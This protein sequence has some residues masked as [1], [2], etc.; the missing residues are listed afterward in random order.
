MR[1]SALLDRLL[2]VVMLTLPASLAAA[3][4][5]A[6]SRVPAAHDEARSPTEAQPTEA[7]ADA[8]QLGR[9]TYLGA[10]VDLPLG[11]AVALSP[12]LALLR[13]AP[14]TSDE[15]TILRS[16]FGI[17]TTL[18][19]DDSWSIQVSGLYGPLAFDIETIEGAIAVEHDI[20]SDWEHEVPPR[21]ELQLEIGVG[22]FR[23]ADGLGPAGENLVQVMFEV[24]ELWRVTHRFHL[25]P[26]GM[27]FV[28]DKSLDQAVGD[29]LGSAM[30]LARVGAFAP[31]LALGGA[32]AAYVVAPWITPYAEVD[33]ILYASR[34]GDAT[35]LLAGASF[36]LGAHVAFGLGGG[37]LLNRPHG[38]LVPDELANRSL[39][40]A[41]TELKLGF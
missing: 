24:K 30:A 36:H 28:Y 9:T 26:Q 23:W 27:F 11:S 7:S 34:S 40:L 33:E 31:P 10:R 21:A 41:T 4:G 32:R 18:R 39:P 2:V 20:G 17:G 3:G 38:P 25:T 13:V 35:Q 6:T 29:R 8:E 14:A 15:R 16:F 12:E 37:V 5:S 22:R 19:P 1:A